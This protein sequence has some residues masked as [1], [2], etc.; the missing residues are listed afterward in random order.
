MWETLMDVWGTVSLE[1]ARMV[2]KLKL[3]TDGNP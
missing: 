1:M 3:D 2:L